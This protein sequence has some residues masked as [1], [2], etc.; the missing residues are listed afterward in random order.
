MNFYAYC[1]SDEVMA[2][3][4]ESAAGV[5]GAGAPR[6]LQYRGIRAVVSE[7]EAESVRLTRENVF[8]HE[9]VIGHVLA[10]T[11]PLPFRFGTVVSAAQLESY[12]DSQ[13]EF[14]QSQL[15]RVRGSVEMSVKVIW[16]VEAVKHEALTGNAKRDVPDVES[17]ITSG[18]GA[19]FLAKKR[20][21]ILGDETLKTRAEEIA[22]WLEG[23]LGEAVR[24]RELRV[25]PME[26][27]VVA[28]AHLVERERLK[29]Y[30]E[31]LR[32]ARQERADLHFLTSG[33]WPPYS[34]SQTN[35]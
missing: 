24:A 4:I 13:R 18:L 29:E 25:R 32:L 17:D 33:P 35:S 6:L 15:E 9:R 3:M 34:F 5:E 8:A 31:R 14:L 7:F 21:E 20:R 19:A 28:A 2:E 11:T 27:L 26:S 12:V 1:L 16:N 22:A 30:Q 23:H 10:H